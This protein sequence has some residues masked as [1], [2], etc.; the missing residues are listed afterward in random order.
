MIIEKGLAKPLYIDSRK[1]CLLSSDETIY[2][3]KG[4]WYVFKRIIDDYHE[5]FSP[6][7]KG[8]RYYYGSNRGIT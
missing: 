8:K 1:V 5:E 2:I 6:V 7:R 3:Y 4:K